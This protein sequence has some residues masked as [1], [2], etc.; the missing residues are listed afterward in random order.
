LRIVIDINPEHW[1]DLTVPGHPPANR[2][3]W[4]LIA[5]CVVNDYRERDA[6]EE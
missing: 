1:D 2:S 4:A 6:A 3:D 5:H